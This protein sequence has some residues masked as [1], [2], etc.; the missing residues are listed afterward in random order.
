MAGW[1]C[2]PH[3]SV[4][5]WGPPAAARHR[6]SRV[7]ARETTEHRGRVMG[8]IEREVQVQGPACHAPRSNTEH[9]YQYRPL[10]RIPIDACKVPYRSRAQSSRL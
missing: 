5:A 8:N 4:V 2:E 9:K 7:S 3:G 10:Y 6:E 1:S